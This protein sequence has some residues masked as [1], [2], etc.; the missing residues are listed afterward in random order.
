MRENRLSGSEG[1]GAEINRLSLPLFEFVAFGE[2]FAATAAADSSRGFQP[3]D[4]RGDGGNY[5][6]FRNAEGGE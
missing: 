4:S 6:G 1:G 5:A 3:T 2:I